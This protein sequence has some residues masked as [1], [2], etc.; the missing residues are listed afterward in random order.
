V[1]T[2]G[3]G[4]DLAKPDYFAVKATITFY[5]HDFEKPPWY[6][7]CPD[8]KCNK[9]VTQNEQDG[10]WYCEKCS[11]AHPEA[12]PRYILS[13]LC[14]DSTGSQ[15]LTAFNESAESLLGMTA[16]EVNDLKDAGNEVAFNRV[17]Q[18]AN[19]STYIFKIRAKADMNQ[20]EQKV[21]CHVLS[22]NKINFKTESLA[23]LDQIAA[24]N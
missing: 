23:L 10:S 19:F 1:A 11:K 8:E 5:R 3:L 20:D 9:K 17:F 12:K 2:E 13:L 7:A 4:N 21:R 22:A 18:D 24:Y 14:C 6:M 15:W 16:P